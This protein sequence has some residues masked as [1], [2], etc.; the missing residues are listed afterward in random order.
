MKK[1]LIFSSLL[2]LTLSA[3]AAVNITEPELIKIDGPAMQPVLNAD[4]TQLQFTAEDLSHRSVVNLADGNVSLVTTNPRT[5]PAH[6]TLTESRDFAEADY[7]SIRLVRNGMEKSISPL[8][9]AH[10]YLWASL[11]PDGSRLLFTEPF[12]GVFV[13]D[14]DGSN[15]VRI[16]AK[17]DFPAWVDNS[18]IA[19]VLSHDD[20]YVILDAAVMVCDL[21]DMSTVKATD[22]ATVVGESS[23]AAGTVVYSTLDGK[24][25]KFN[26]KH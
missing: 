3:Q 6:S 8:K 12:Q 18:T 22:N 11:S 1:I 24:I 2:A 26:V 20:G 7:K 25:Y 10:S 19:Y 21:T 5:A 17:G 23:A 15:P 16:A 13:A 14:A 4:A 9:D